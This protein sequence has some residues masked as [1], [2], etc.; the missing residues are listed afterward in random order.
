MIQPHSFGDHRTSM[1]TIV[2]IMMVRDDYS[3]KL[4]CGGGAPLNGECDAR[5]VRWEYSEYLSISAWPW[6]ISITGW[7]LTDFLLPANDWLSPK[8]PGLISPLYMDPGLEW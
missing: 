5:P 2:V 6:G 7:R 8:K 4:C 1:I 3:W